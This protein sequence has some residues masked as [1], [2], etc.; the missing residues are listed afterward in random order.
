MVEF[1]IKWATKNSAVWPNYLTGFDSK[2]NAWWQ[3]FMVSVFMST[4]IKWP[5]LIISV[6]HWKKVESLLKGV[7]ATH[8]DGALMSRPSGSTQPPSW[9]RERTPT[10]VRRMR[11]KHFCP[12]WGMYRLLQNCSV[13]PWLGLHTAFRWRNHQSRF[14]RLALPQLGQPT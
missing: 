7:K 3:R 10:G 13:L 4:L 14:G 1:C 6:M 5:E 12:Q 2:K 8:V 11:E 9:G